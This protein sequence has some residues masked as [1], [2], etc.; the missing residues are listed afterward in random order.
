LQRYEKNFFERAFLF[1][2][3]MIQAN[4]PANKAVF[5]SFKTKASF[6]LKERPLPLKGRGRWF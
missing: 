5:S 4:I 3:F 2:K 1:K 6:L